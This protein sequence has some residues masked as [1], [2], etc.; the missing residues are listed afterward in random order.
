MESRQVVILGAGPAGLTAAYQLA[1]AGVTSNV[2]EGDDTVG[3]LARTVLYNGYRFDIGGHR[4]Y[5]KVPAVEE[6]W[7]EILGDDLLTRSRLSR[8][9]YNGKFFSYPLKPLS[10]LEGLGLVETLRCLAS[11]GRARLKPLRPEDDFAS[12][13]TNRFGS[14]LF[15]LFFKTYTEKVWGIP[16]TEIQA[17]WAAQ[18]IRGLSLSTAIK[19]AVF[20]ERAQNKKDVVKTLVDRFQYPRH[21]P[22]MM[23]ERTRDEV[24]KRGSSV[25]LNAP[26]TRIFWR[27]GAVE[28]VEAGGEVF[29]GRHFISSIAIRDLIECMMPSPPE[30]VMQAA[31]QL[32][33]RD[34]LT[35]ALVLRRRD[36]FPDNWIYVHDPS[37]RMGRIQNFNNW[38]PEMVPDPETTCLGLEYFCFEGDGLWSMPDEELMELGKVELRKLGLARPEDVVDGAVVR[39]RK[40]YP[41]YDGQYA[42]AVQTIRTFLKCLPNLQL[43]GRNGM[44]RYN[45]QDHSMFTALLAAR[46]ILGGKYDLWRVNVEEEYLE[47]GDPLTLA[48]I[49]TL[50]ET[51]PRTPKKLAPRT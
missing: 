47:D 23:W 5:T 4:F 30:S 45:N 20:G 40:A 14:R 22:G 9:Y 34:F 11:Y 8:I 7:R 31:A 27:D 44:H 18:R 10:A 37:V 3:G 17:E 51:Q 1:K 41:I 26:V 48:D 29:T 32:Q 43:V 33:Y 13:V 15:E 28:G 2:L 12:W 16:C 21:G 50:Q 36:I 6:I 39:M 46:N 49:E 19:N 38:S 35:V 24:E 42:P 25:R